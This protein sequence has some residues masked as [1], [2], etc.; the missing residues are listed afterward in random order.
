MA[1]GISTLLAFAI[2]E[3]VRARALV[4]L[5]P[6]I[7]DPGA[8]HNA[9]LRGDIVLG[10]KA[11]RFAPPS[12]DAALTAVLGIA[13]SAIV[14]LSD[15]GKSRVAD[16]YLYASEIVSIVLLALGLKS[17]EANSIAATAMNN[18]RKEHT[19]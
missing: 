8:P 10:M 15:T 14:R 2:A 11:G 7:A 3:P 5:E 16:P 17:R 6:G 4:R 9:G 18:R 12:A 1:N 19:R 13:L